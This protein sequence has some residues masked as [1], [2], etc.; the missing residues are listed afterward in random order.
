MLHCSEPI[1]SLQRFVCLGKNWGPGLSEVHILGLSLGYYE[2]RGL[3]ED[4]VVDVPTRATD[5]YCQWWH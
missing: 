1:V 5:G 4:L 3:G 2:L